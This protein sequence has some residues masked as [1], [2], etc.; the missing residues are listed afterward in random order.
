MGWRLRTCRGGL[1]EDRVGSRGSKA[2]P[3][4]CRSVVR[5]ITLVRAESGK[6]TP[7]DAAMTHAASGRACGSVDLNQER[8]LVRLLRELAAERG[9][10]VATLGDGWI[11]RIERDASGS[12]PARVAHVYGYGF[13]L[14]PAGTHAIACDK[15]ATS[16][17][18]TSCGVPNV[19]HRLFLHPRMA[20][21][22]PH[23]GTWE[24]ILASFEAWDRDVVVKENA[25]TGGRDVVRCRSVVELEEAVYSLFEHT[26]AI[27]I[28][29]YLELSH[30][31]RFVMLGGSVEL[32]YEKVRFAVVGDG[33]RT[34]LQLLSD[35]TGSVTGDAT[36]SP[37]VGRGALA[38]MFEQMDA[39]TRAS[40]LDVPP[41]GQTRL[42]NWRHN[43][44]QGASV[45]LLDVG[46]ARVAACARV[47]EAA[48]TAIGL[49]FGSVDVVIAGARPAR[50]LEINAGVMMEFLVRSLREGEALAR[51]VYGQALDAMMR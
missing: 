10:R 35:A 48:A 30:E 39:G 22:V 25:G 6:Q 20:R 7:N 41:K 11:L 17:L 40:L 29:P 42:L 24:Q 31:H 26:T 50:V 4:R 18:L 43:L 1:W 16:E 8:A 38:G 27:A 14:N 36:G 9:M 32:A 46:E 33:A 5:P 12:S 15:A 19:E 13:D 28:S 2:L 47:A 44:G 49:R 23:R 21:F 45:R 37:R 3:N 51:R 34:T